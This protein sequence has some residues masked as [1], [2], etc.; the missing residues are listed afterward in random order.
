[1][2]PAMSARPHSLTVSAPLDPAFA[3]CALWNRAYRETVAATGRA[4]PLIIALEGEDGR[5]TRYE[6]T[7]AAFRRWGEQAK[8]L[9]TTASSGPVTARAVVV[10]HDLDAELRKASGGKRTVA[11]LVRDF[12]RRDE[13]ATLASLRTAAG[14]VTGK[15][16][17]AL[18]PA[19][20]PGLD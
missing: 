6:T 2:M 9:R 16:P 13:P 15:P 4:V 10:F 3:P 17:R 19:A 8:S 18:A 7:I 1:M 11:A 14:K 5:I 20:V 12:L